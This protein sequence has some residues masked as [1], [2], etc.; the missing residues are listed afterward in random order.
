MSRAKVL[1]PFLFFLAMGLVTFTGTAS[2]YSV[3]QT[4][5]IDNTL[6]DGFITPAG[7]GID[8]SLIHILDPNMDIRAFL[9]FLDVHIDS[10]EFLDNATLRLTSASTLPFDADSSVTV[11]GMAGYDLQTLS[12]LAIYGPGTLLSWAPTSAHVDVNTSQFYGGAVLD[13]DVTDIVQEIYEHPHWDGDLLGGVGT[14]DA[15]GF[16]IFGA[17]DEI[18]YFY[19]YLG[20]PARTADLIIGYNNNPPPPSGGG[21]FNESYRGRN[22]FV[23]DH[24]GPNRTGEGADVNWNKLNMTDLTEIDS[25]NALTVNDA[26]RTSINQLVAQQINSLYND[27]GG[28]GVGTY[29]VRFALNVSGVTNPEAF[30]DRVATVVGISTASPVGGGGLMEGAGGDF[31]GLVMTIRTNDEEFTLRLMDRTGVNRQYSGSFG[32]WD[33]AT[34]ERI[35]IEYMATDTWES[36]R[37]FSDAN[38]TNQLFFDTR[39]YAGASGPFRYPQIISSLAF[40]VSRINT[41]EYYTFLTDVLPDN[42][43]WVVTHPNGTDASC[44]TLLTYEEALIC[45]DELSGGPHPQ[46]PDPPGLGYPTEGPFTRFRMRAYI[47]MTGFFCVFG[48]I[49]FFAWKKPSM[50]YLFVGALIIIT[51]LGL[52]MSVATI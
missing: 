27:T 9:I 52:M 11:Y 40:G 41:A 19:D 23:V 44:K 31:V 48:P 2:G 32:L 22:I 17:E 36:V 25:G 50:Y 5:N 10:W 18:R 47:F 46:E 49:W 39:V 21:D 37:V 38:Y 29:F 14:G 6:H 4:I 34:N 16:L 20:D 13:I 43:T 3:I 30:N 7:I 1:I 45:I 51:G 8:S 42:T 24:N 12:G 15:M 28:L 33:E 26:T 35:Y